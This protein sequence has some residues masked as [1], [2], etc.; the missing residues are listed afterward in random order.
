LV[1]GTILQ[2]VSG[3]TCGTGSC[4]WLAVDTG[5]HGTLNQVKPTFNA[6][7]ITDEYQPL[8]K[9]LLN[10][11]LRYE[12]FQFQGV[13]IMTGARP[14]WFAA[15]NNAYCGSTTPG[16]GV[17]PGGFYQTATTAQ[18]GPGTAPLNSSAALAITGGDAN[19]LYHVLEP[20]VS[21]TYTMNP[22]NVFRF[23]YGRYAQPADTAAEQYNEAQENLPSFLGSIFY[24]YGFHAAG[25]NIPPEVSNNYDFSWE[26]QFKGTDMS[27]KITPFWRSTQGEQTAFFIDP[28]QAF[29]SNIP[30]GNLTS[31]G[32][33]FAFNKGDFNRNGLSGQLAFTYTY[34]DIKYT[35]LPNG[36]TPLSVINNDVATFNAF[37]SF[38]ASNPKDAR[39]LTQGGATPTD[40]NTGNAIV[41]SPCYDTSGN[42]VACS[43]TGAIANPYWNAP[44]NSLF[45]LSGPYLPTDTVVA[46]TGLNANTYAVPYTATLLLHYKHDRFSITPSLQMEAGQRYGVPEN[47]EGIDPTTCAAGIGGLASN[48]PRYMGGTAGQGG[49]AY[50]A[51]SCSGA[52]MAI[53]DVYTNNHF[54]QIGGFVAPTQLLANL[55][56]TYDVSPKVT[57]QLTMANLANACFG[58]TKTAWTAALANSRTCSWTGTASA[59]VVNPVGNFYNPGTTINRAFQYP[60]Q[61]YAGVYNP[62]GQT[63]NQPFSVYLD[64]QIKL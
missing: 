47:T 20:R 2:N 16:T 38:C 28:L 12:T 19:Y 39:C 11:G 58:G 45:N 29:V 51:T 35:A 56:M 60:Y 17:T 22:N 24:P 61:P 5:N 3:T 33:E 21:G 40:P 62:D 25:H 6:Y 13:P 41:A 36:G 49:S 1:P 57:L 8:D 42:A 9:L 32:V 48:D 14:F 63:P 31:K 34:T 46:T 30:V 43:A 23:S 26:H 64:A 37:T 15:Y 55:Q 52:L 59:F 7:S 50:D 4:E 54:D 18:C 53:P 44:V 10:L 27:M